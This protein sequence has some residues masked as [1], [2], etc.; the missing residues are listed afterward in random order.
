[1]QATVASY[2][3]DTRSGTVL[4][5]DGMVLGFEAG[6]L[7]GAHIRHLRSGQRLIVDA[8]DEPD[9]QRIVGVRIH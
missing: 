3:E 6:A 8:T 5:D 9:G 7:E 4:L 1:M 2:D